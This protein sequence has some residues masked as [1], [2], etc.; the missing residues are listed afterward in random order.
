MMNSNKPS[1]QGGGQGRRPRRETKG[2]E[3]SEFDQRVIEV[4]RVTRVMAGG[5]RMRFRACVVV[6]N[7]KGRIGFGLGKGA[8]FALAVSKAVT[9][10]KKNILDLPLV[11]TTIPH[12]TK[13]K[14]KAAKLLLKPAP[15]GT[16]IM[17]GGAVRQALEVSGIG[18]IAT[19]VFGSK[20][21]VNNIQALF[22]A[23]KLMMHTANIKKDLLEERESQ[24]AK[25]KEKESIHIVSEEKNDEKNS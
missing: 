4:S 1:Q 23:F 8:D 25:K 16:G 9:R 2:A 10:A 13:V 14:F 7:H 3:I 21:K 18:N 24:K 17:A 6:G 19:K 5:K 12:Q 15:E 20:N 11:D 22:E